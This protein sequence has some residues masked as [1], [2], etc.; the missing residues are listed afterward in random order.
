[1]E[2]NGD[3]NEEVWLIKQPPRDRYENRGK[4]RCNEPAL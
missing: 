3:F 1:M 2:N 4:D